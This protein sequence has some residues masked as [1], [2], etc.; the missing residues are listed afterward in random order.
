MIDAA[1]ASRLMKVKIVIVTNIPDDD[2]INSSW[3]PTTC[4][5]TVYTTLQYSETLNNILNQ[6]S[7]NGQ[8]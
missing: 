7:I 8:F 2:I 6:R 4:T 1:E 5:R 3:L